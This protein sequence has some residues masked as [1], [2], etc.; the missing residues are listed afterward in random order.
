M[1]LT[2]RSIRARFRRLHWHPNVANVLGAGV[3]NTI[4]A[5]GLRSCKQAG[6]LIASD[7]DKMLLTS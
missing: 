4:L 6:H 5:N 3:A 7:Q 1:V 2:D